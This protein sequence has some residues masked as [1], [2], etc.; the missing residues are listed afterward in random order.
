MKNLATLIVI[1]AL[2]QLYPGLVFADD[3]QDAPNSTKQTGSEAGNSSPPPQGSPAG[4]RN[5][6]PFEGVK[7]FFNGLSKRLNSSGSNDAQVQSPPAGVEPTQAPKSESA[8]TDPYR[9]CERQLGTAVFI[10]AMDGVP[11]EARGYYQLG[12]PQLS[13]IADHVAKTL[14]CFDV[15]ESNLTMAYVPGAAEPDFVLRVRPLE[16]KLSVDT[17]S[18]AKGLGIGVVGIAA[19][20]SM[21]VPFGAGVGTAVMQA[22]NPTPGLVNTPMQVDR[23]L[24]GIEIMCPKQR[25]VAAQFSGSEAPLT[26][27]GDKRYIFK[28]NDKVN[29]NQELVAR[30]YVKAQTDLVNYLSS[31][32]KVCAEPSRAK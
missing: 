14:K 26:L 3:T 21:L 10:E 25:R 12:V 19:G 29:L 30:A 13:K 15:L 1:I 5:N 20:L 2:L 31:Q 17:G 18:V 23:V 16:V 9:N 27:E 32:T 28:W 6:N 22:A 8:N 4:E 24:V 7:S 11:Q